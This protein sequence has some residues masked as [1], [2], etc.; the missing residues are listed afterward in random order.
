[1]GR[2]DRKRRPARR[3][4]LL[5]PRQRILVL[6]EGEKTEPDYIRGLQKW[7]RNH[8]VDV[9][10]SSERGVPLTLVRLAK[11][12]NAKAR[13]E[14]KRHHDDFF[15]YDQVW[16]VFDVD[17]HPK[18]DEAIDMARANGIELAISSPCFELWLLLHFR[19]NPGA[20]HRHDMQAM[21]KTFVASYDKKIDFSIYE[22]RYMDAMQRALR[23]QRACDDDGEP[24]RNPSTGVPQL[25]EVIRQY[26]SAGMDSTRDQPDD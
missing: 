22:P 12:Q 15:A 26:S 25:T 13:A 20:Q 11:E 14:A 4:H 24:H 8:L 6:C 5:E 7:C 3:K 23:L 16:C 21:M 10:I 17:E 1:M 2:G 9:V 19:E 18:L